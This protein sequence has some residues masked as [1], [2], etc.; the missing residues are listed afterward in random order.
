MPLLIFSL[1][2]TELDIYQNSSRTPPPLRINIGGE[3]SKGDKIKGKSNKSIIS[4]FLMLLSVK[5][6]KQA[7]AELCQAQV[8]LS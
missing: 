6:T 1:V 4:I 3:L 2:V 5:E 7:G 8:R